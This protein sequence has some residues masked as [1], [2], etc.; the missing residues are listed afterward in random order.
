ME[1]FEHDHASFDTPASITAR[2]LFTYLM[3][4]ASVVGM[5]ITAYLFAS[6]LALRGDY[7]QA[8]GERAALSGDV[9]TLRDQITDLG[10]TPKAPPPEERVGTIPPAVVERGAPGEDGTD[11]T[12]GVDGEDGSDGPE[13]PRGP[14]GP[15]G[16]P[17]DDGDNGPPGEP[18]PPGPAGENGIPG[19]PGINGVPGPQGEMGPQGLPGPA[20]PAGP[21]GEPGADGV[22]GAPGPAGATGPQGPPGAMPGGIVVPDGQGGFCTARDYT[23]DGVYSCEENPV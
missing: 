11:G 4:G 7:Q 2:R 5:A 20:G 15:Q 12:D 16:P 23:G 19:A 3:W 18:G 13:G 22:D 17:G 1:P 10:A 8:E 9:L 6:F 14:A 21:A